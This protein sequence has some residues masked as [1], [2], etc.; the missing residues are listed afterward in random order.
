MS[1]LIPSALA[2][3]KLAEAR[4]LRRLLASCCSRPG[5]VERIAAVGLDLSVRGHG[6]LASK[7]ASFGSFAV[8]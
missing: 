5:A 4:A 3:A 2:E 6:E 7:S 1:Y 8:G